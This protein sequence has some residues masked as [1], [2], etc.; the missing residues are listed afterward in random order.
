MIDSV[1]LEV[2]KD[3][4]WGNFALTVNGDFAY[5]VLLY[6][7]KNDN[8]MAS[9]FALIGSVGGLTATYFLFYGV[10]LLLK[11][12]L[13]RNPSYPQSRHYVSKLAPVFG[14]ITVMPQV[15]VIPAFFFGIAKM[16]FKRFLVIT[17]FYRIIFY[18]YMLN[19]TP[20]LPS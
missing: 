5:T 17:I 2:L 11:N 9:L 12:V 20:V 18:A 4:F 10:A 7:G 6:F 8:L 13:E 16:N 14:V 15:C 19:S 1:Y 3:S